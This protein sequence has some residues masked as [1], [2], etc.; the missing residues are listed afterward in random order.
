M[1]VARRTRGP[2]YA[3]LQWRKPREVG[4]VARQTLWDLTAVVPDC[5]CF[6][7]SIAQIGPNLMGRLDYPF[8]VPIVRWT[9]SEIMA[10]EDSSQWACYSITIIISRKSRTA[11]WLEEGINQGKGTCDTKRWIHRWSIE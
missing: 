6:V 3:N 11:S 2:A 7:S 10:T 4:E 5:E 8:I 9:E 1:K